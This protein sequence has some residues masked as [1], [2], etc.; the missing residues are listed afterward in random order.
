MTGRDARE[1]IKGLPGAVGSHL[2]PGGTLARL[3]KG[4]RGAKNVARAVRGVGSV[5]GN[6]VQTLIENPDADFEDHKKAAVENLIASM[7]MRAAHGTLHTIESGVSYVFN[8]S[9]PAP[10]T[11]G[12]T[13]SAVGN[14]PETTTQLTAPG[15][16]QPGA[17][18]P[19]PPLLRPQ[20]VPC[21]TTTAATAIHSP[22]QSCGGGTAGRPRHPLPCS[23][24]PFP[25]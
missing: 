21:K 23:R 20:A 13:P 2:V 3:G 19:A 11:P 4:S 8:P 1:D 10:G 18:P 12:W 15:A 25:R 14:I 9:G 22:R 16:A 24:P 5:G 17:G 6:M 7:G